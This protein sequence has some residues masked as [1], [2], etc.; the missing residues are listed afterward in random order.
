MLLPEDFME[1][2]NDDNYVRMI[3]DWEMETNH[4]IPWFWF[5][6]QSYES[7]CY[8]PFDGISQNFPWDYNISRLRFHCELK[9][10]DTLPIFRGFGASKSEARMNVCKLAY[11]YLEE[12]GYI[13]YKTMRDE[14]DQPAKENAINQLEILARRGYFSIPFY[15]KVIRFKNAKLCY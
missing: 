15:D 9:L 7:S 1:N 13:H 8:F 6:E 2:D 3:Y 5:K 10:L 14:I 12:N 11:E 4:V